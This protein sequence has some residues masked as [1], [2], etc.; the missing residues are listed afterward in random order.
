MISMNLVIPG[1]RLHLRNH[2]YF[3]ATFRQRML[4]TAL[5]VPPC[6]RHVWDGRPLL[7]F[8]ILGIDPRSVPGFASAALLRT[9]VVAS[10]MMNAGKAPDTHADAI[11]KIKLH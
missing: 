7:P 6:T 9:P 11:F 4:C 8:R 2:L 3:G 5:G 10:A 1:F